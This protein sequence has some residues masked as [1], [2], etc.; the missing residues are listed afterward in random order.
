MPTG[1]LFRPGLLFILF[2][3]PFS[4]RT[5]SLF[6]HLSSHIPLDLPSSHLSA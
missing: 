2:P 6:A 1:C 3:V 4:I 5:F